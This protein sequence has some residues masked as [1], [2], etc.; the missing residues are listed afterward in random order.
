MK[1]NAVDVMCTM[2]ITL[3]GGQTP[4]FR[5]RYGRPVREGHGE[6]EA[7]EG[8]EQEVIVC[9][10]VESIKGVFQNMAGILPKLNTHWYV[11]HGY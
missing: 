8:H 1:T 7:A 5:E 2:W 6:D 11:I 10:L 4:Y 9:Q 3:A